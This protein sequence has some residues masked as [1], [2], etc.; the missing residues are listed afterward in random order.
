MHV[1]GYR[2][3]RNSIDGPA[4]VNV[5][6][7][8]T[9]EAT[10]VTLLGEFFRYLPQALGQVSE[11]A[12]GSSFAGAEGVDLRGI[13][14]D[15]TLTLLNGKRVA[16]YARNGASEPFVDINAI[17]IAAIERVEILNDGASAI[18][19]SDAVAGV[20]NIILR[21]EFD[22]LQLGGGYL[23]TT[24]GDGDEWT[25]DLVWGRTGERTRVLAT[26]SVSD[27]S[28]ILARD[29]EGTADVD[30]SDVGGPNFRAFNSTPANYFS[31]DSFQ[32]IADAECGVEPKIA[33]IET[34]PFFGDVCLFNYAWFQQLTYDRQ[35]LS[36]NMVVTHDFDTG[37]TGRIEVLYSHRKNRALLAPSP[38]IGG[39][40]PANH[41]NNPYGALLEIAGRPLDTGNRIF[42]TSADT[43]R[44][45]AGLEGAWKDWAWSADLLLSGN[46]TD[47]DRL[48]AVYSDRYYAALAGSGGPSGDQWYNPFG[49][50]PSNDPELIDWMTTR[51]RFGADSE[52]NALDLE[53]STFFGALPG[54][55]VG[56]AA[57]L[58][59]REQ[60]L[61]E[62]ADEVERSGQLAG[63]SQITQITADRDILAAY[64]EFK[65]PLLSTVEAQLAVRYDEYS[66]F[67]SSTN[68]KMALAWR[69]G[70]AWLFRASYGTSFRPPTFTE[71]FNPET[72]NS[73]FYE[74]VERCEVTGAPADCAQREYPV[75]DTGNPE[76]EPESGESTLFG[77]VWSPGFLDGFDLEVDYWRFEHSDRIVQ[78]DPQLILDAKNN[79]G[80]TR[81]P[82]SAEDI[83][84][85]IPGPIV[86]LTR[87][88][89][90]SDRL[91]TS[92]VDV[93]GRYLWQ[94]RTGMRF[95]TTLMYT[96]VGDYTLKDAAVGS[97]ESGIN[98]AGRHYNL[99]F[100]I[101]RHRG[102]LNINWQN[103]AHGMAANVRYTG[104][105]EGAF[106]VT[107]D[108][109]SR[110]HIVDAYTT[111][112]LQYTYQ[113]GA[114]AT[115]IRL[116]CR[117]CF[118]NDPPDTFLYLGE[119]LYDYRG[120][121]VYT[122]LEHH[123]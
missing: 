17:P 92:G 45:V 51:T 111:L 53:A 30:Y 104:D 66:D 97:R 46:Q 100:G 49:A 6:D 68:P 84:L 67:G 91:V 4:P 85:G 98:F 114:D 63:G 96:Y 71:L 9:L 77:V 39:L 35:A 52:E 65:L 120:A 21:E 74:D 60:S 36:G 44:V 108:G 38:V 13:G 25:A 119:G 123:F 26:V 11:L 18:Y 62:F 5:F 58:Q 94:S 88:Y 80:V 41:P 1:T 82:P 8:E 89:L 110:P 3:K 48:N 107:I 54:G 61:D 101:P 102:N 40:I 105:Y 78:L 42:D 81:L 57:G 73:G 87:T 113:F 2:I 22:G 55:A 70:D 33:D 31:L 121:M 12:Q 28:P 106:D 15:N 47:T 59:Y 43:Y 27:K 50:H 79:D 37:V 95:D 69:P 115:R 122:R 118:D 90:N 20:V 23:T 14:I 64:A 76:L 7:R 72:F 16:A 83:A 117:N 24:E 19:G 109:A 112:D 116:G 29:R 93:S 32:A 86:E 103:G 34:F 99:E 10:G 56:F 75:R